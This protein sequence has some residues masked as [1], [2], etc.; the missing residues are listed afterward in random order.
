MTRRRGLIHG[1]SAL[2]AAL[3]GGTRPVAAQE[4]IELPARDSFLVGAFVEQYRA[5][6]VTDGDWDTFGDIGDM[7]FDAAGNL[8]IF[9]TQALTVSVVDRTGSLVRRFGERG[10]GPGE[11]ESDF[12]ELLR[13]AVLPDGRAVVYAWNR[14]AFMVF[15]S[16][17]EFERMLRMPGGA[18][19]TF[20]GL[21]ALPGGDA[22]LATSP[23]LRSPAAPRAAGRS[24]TGTRR[25]G[26]AIERFRLEGYRAVA[27][28]V[29]EAWG[30][31]GEPAAFV[32]QVV[33]GA[34][35]DG[36]VA[37]TDSS[38]YAIKIVSPAGEPVRVLTRPFR[39]DPVTE[40]H[41]SLF[42]G[43]RLKL[44]RDYEKELARLGGTYRDIADRMSESSRQQA[45]A[46]EFYHEVPVVQTLRTTW[47]GGIWVQRRGAGLAGDGPIDILTSDGRYLGT[48]PPS[49]TPMPAAFGP[50]GLMAI[51]E[52]NELDVQKVVVRQ[53]P[54]RLR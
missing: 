14:G 50:D 42:T 4:V 7:A 1:L 11:F 34:L 43:W 52:T 40:R 17:G 25:S 20:L 31:P 15:G 9:D 19:T 10:E 16:D 29:V 44:E 30:P 8:Y 36:G 27:D 53:L 5:G 18:R 24:R 37:Y 28:T 26:R 3:H 46:T 2:L 48:Y 12:G 51:V 41:K 54:A 32:P 13:L 47:N 39:P 22:V 49:A 33:G 45:E 6:S 35:P 23:V 38:A 21:Q